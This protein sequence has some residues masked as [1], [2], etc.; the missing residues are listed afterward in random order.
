MRGTRPLNFT[1]SR[2][3]DVDGPVVLIAARS[4]ASERRWPDSAA[5]ASAL[6]AEGARV[7][8][9]SSDGTISGGVVS[10]LDG[11]ALFAAADVVVASHGAGLVNSLVLRPGATLLEVMPQVREASMYCSAG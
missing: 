11:L 1:G 6:E 3:K 8:Y 7:L 5:V 4:D 9:Y 10:P 2:G